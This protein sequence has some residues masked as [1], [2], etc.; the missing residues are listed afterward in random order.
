MSDQVEFDN[1]WFNNLK[2]KTNFQYFIFCFVFGY[3]T[4]LNAIAGHELLHRK[5]TPNKIIG[6]WAYTKFMYTHFLDEHIKGHHR[7][8]ATPDDPSTAR[9]NEWFY[10]F[11]VREYFTGLIK[12][13]NRE[14]KRI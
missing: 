9:K 13:W 2:P 7:D 6:T 14:T 11:I 10:C 12:T 4:G 8:V 5:E 1:I 3:Y